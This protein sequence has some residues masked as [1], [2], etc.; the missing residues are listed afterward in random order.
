MLI[1]VTITAE[2]LTVL[3]CGLAGVQLIAMLLSAGDQRLDEDWHRH[4]A[5]PIG[6][7]RC[8]TG[9]TKRSAEV[10]VISKQCDS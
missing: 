2:L 6:D 10:R 4:V 3:S 7:Q 1:A 9:N 8:I 5:E